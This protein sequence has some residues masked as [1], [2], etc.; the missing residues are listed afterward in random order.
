[1]E[2][3]QGA[4]NKNELSVIKRF[5]KETFSMIIHPDLDI[6]RKSIHLLEKYA[7]SDGLRTVDSLIVA[8]ALKD[9][10]TLATANY[11]HFQYI[12]NLNVLKFFPI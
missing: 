2:L 11:R 8:S 9:N 6:S 3:I 4:L 12:P 1:M 10:A 7:L 5:I